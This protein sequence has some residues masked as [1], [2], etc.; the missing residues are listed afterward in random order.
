[1]NQTKPDLATTVGGQ[2]V[3]EFHFIKKERKY[4]INQSTQN[5]Q[6]YMSGPTQVAGF[7]TYLISGDV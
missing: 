5:G 3:S 2:G 4:V 6:K 1:M 7:Q